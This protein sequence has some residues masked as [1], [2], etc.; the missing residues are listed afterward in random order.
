MNPNDRV[1]FN[2]TWFKD[3]YVVLENGKGYCDLDMYNV[4]RQGYQ[5]VIRFAHEYG[6]TVIP[7]NKAN[8][9][10]IYNFKREDVRDSFPE[11]SSHF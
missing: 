10:K 5:H 11:L 7:N 3:R 8:R 2:G 6:F 9:C 1:K 4:E